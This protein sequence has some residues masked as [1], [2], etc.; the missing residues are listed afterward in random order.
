[1][2]NIAIIIFVAWLSL[3]LAQDNNAT[4]TEADSDTLDGRIVG[5]WDTKIAH[6]PHQISLQLNK[7]HICGGVIVAPHLILTAAHCVLK[8]TQPELYAIRAGSSFWESGGSYVRIKRI[9]PH[10]HF[11]LPT[12]MNNDIA[13]LL[14]Q[15]P[16]VYSRD[17]QAI[18]LVHPTDYV[19]PHAQLFVSGWGSTNA[20]QITTATRL[21][22]TALVELD[23]PSCTHNYVGSGVVTATMFCAGSRTGLGDRDS[24]LGDS[25]GPLVTNVEGH[26]KLLGIVSWGLGC[27]SAQYPGVYTQVSAYGDWLTHLSQSLF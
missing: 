18:Q 20:Q 14:L 1:M 8:H 6:F 12:H 25:G 24:C 2:Q 4:Q 13:L 15:R 9:I 7:K 21:H 5:G 11:N 3:T 27:A 10:E 17:I 26:F 19:A 23:H 22:Y 16:L